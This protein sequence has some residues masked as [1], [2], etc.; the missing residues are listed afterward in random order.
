VFLAF[1]TGALYNLMVNRDQEVKINFTNSMIITKI[2]L[3]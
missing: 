1:R 2:S 3:T